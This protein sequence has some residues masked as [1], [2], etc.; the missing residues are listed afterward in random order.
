MKAAPA[1]HPMPQS[2]GPESEL[3]DPA[4]LLDQQQQVLAQLSRWRLLIC[5]AE[6]P[7]RLLLLAQLLD[8]LPEPPPQRLLG[9]CRRRSD[10]AA[11]LPS[12]ASDVLVLAQD[13]LLD[14][15]ALPMLSELLQRPTPP[16]VLLSCCTPHRAVIREARQVGV[17]AL[18]S[19]AN[20]G[21]G[22]LLEALAALAEGRPFLDPDCRSV[23]NEAGPASAE[24]TAREVEILALVAEGCTNRRI[25]ERLQIA[26][27]TA[28][29]HVQR[30]LSKLQ[31]PDRAAAAVSGMRLGYLR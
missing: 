9:L 20:V 31:V 10:V 22:I 11:R 26:E 25:A 21:R 27:V 1:C 2:P 24:L 30:I 13:F 17:Q 29:D 16:T 7:S 12:D 3:P 8:R 19:Q 6:R 5:T 14:G 18:I 28:R 15:P 4:W 23:L